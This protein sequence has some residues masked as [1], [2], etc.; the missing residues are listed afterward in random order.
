MKIM[1]KLIDQ[2]CKMANKLRVRCIPSVLF[3]RRMVVDTKNT[4]L[5]LILGHGRK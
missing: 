1:I 2:Y 3:N 5:Y 4:F